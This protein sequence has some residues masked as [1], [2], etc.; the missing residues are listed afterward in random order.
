MGWHV[1]L[2]LLPLAGFVFCVMTLA[3][4]GIAKKLYQSPV[5]RGKVRKSRN[6][7]SADWGEQKGIRVMHKNGM[8]TLVNRLRRAVSAHSAS[9]QTD[10]QLVQRFVASRDEEAFEAL[11]LRH[12][13]MVLGV[14]RRVLGNAH[15]AE[16]AFQAC[17]AK[18]A[19]KL[20]ERTSGR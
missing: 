16:D 2:M 20:P 15:D 5:W 17:P 3:S 13:P 19:G 14:C 9:E 18:A 4:H 8:T 10:A 1:V 6:W 7:L 12:G 11:V